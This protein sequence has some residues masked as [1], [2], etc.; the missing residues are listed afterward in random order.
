[1][2]DGM[3]GDDHLNEILD[4]IQDTALESVPL[5]IAPKKWLA[6]KTAW[7]YVR[8]MSATVG[9]AVPIVAAVGGAGSPAISQVPPPARVEDVGPH[10]PSQGHGS[11]EPMR[12]VI[13]ATT[14]AAPFSLTGWELRSEQGKFYYVVSGR[15][16]D[17]DHSGESPRNSS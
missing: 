12:S 15:N 13:V 10:I 8:T 11:A 1:M 9:K 2:F 7:S 5:A 6:F 16:G 17:Q 3:A 4:T 14:S